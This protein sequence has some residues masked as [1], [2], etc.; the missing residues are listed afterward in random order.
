MGCNAPERV[1]QA[2]GVVFRID[3]G[4]LQ[5]LLVRP[6]DGLPEWLFPKGHIEPGELEHDAAL[7]E[8]REEAGIRGRL[9]GAVENP[10]CFTSKGELVRVRYFAIEALD[11]V[12][13]DELR[14][15]LW[16]PPALAAETLTH[17]EAR[18][19]LAEAMP[20][21]DGHLVAS[22]RGDPSF[23]GFLLHELAH[24]EESLIKSE[25]D[26]ERR[27]TMFVTLAAGVGAVLAFV[28]GKDAGYSPQDIAAPVVLALAA[29]IVLGYFMLLRVVTRNQ[30]S[31]NYKVRLN[32][33]RRWFVPSA[34]DPRRA[35]LPFDPFTQK[36]RKRLSAWGP[37][38]GGWLET[39]ILVEAFLGGGFAAALVP[40][41]DWLQEGLV[42]VLG[43]ALTWMLMTDRARTLVNKAR[44]AQ[45]RDMH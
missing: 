39:L 9:V 32:N 28:T 27:V 10:S 43:A 31:D 24:A 11:T 44:A 30:A 14:A 12:E 6:H 1:H 29:L 8:V 25:E 21:V 17:D 5:I 16:L 2:G 19:T 18:R 36:P 45:E 40:S 7:R 20:L 38:S 15:Q 26:G 33:L 23:R 34:A 41:P 13:S 35:W 22:G 3:Q 42:A 37:G 4:L